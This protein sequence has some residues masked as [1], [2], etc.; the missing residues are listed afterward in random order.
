MRRGRSLYEIIQVDPMAE[1]EVLEAAFRRLAR[2][3][4]PDI[5]AMP[6]GAQ[7]MKELNAAYEVLRD[8]GRRAAYDRERHGGRGFAAADV[9]SRPAPAPRAQRAWLTCRQHP[10]MAATGECVECGTGLCGVC[11][12]RFRPARCTTCM[13]SWSSRRRHRLLLPGLWFFIVLGALAYLLASSTQLL[14][15]GLP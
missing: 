4:H 13:G 14:G 10:M 12:D 2:K 5:S 7:R 9:V 3:Y 11:F 8:P 1:P 6:D 15:H